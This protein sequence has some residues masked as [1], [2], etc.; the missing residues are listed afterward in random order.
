[1]QLEADFIA[2]IDSYITDCKHES[3]EPEKPFKGNFNV[4]I[5]PQ[6]HQKAA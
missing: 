5:S 3:V 6:L 1:M 4:R 2:A